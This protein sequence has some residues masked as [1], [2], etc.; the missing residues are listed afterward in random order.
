MTMIF[1][2]SCSDLPSILDFS[3]VRLPRFSP[4]VLHFLESQCFL[5]CLTLKKILTRFLDICSM[6]HSTFL[7][8]LSWVKAP[9]TL[10]VPWVF[11]SLG[12]PS[13]CLILRFRNASFWMFETFFRSILLE[14]WK[15][16]PQLF[17]C[18]L[19][20]PTSTFV[21]SLTSGNAF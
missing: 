2:L 13:E 11:P 20:F 6:N 3:L 5:R 14:F 8:A 12:D 17:T 1:F 9:N 19:S 21:T 10:V 16:D 4:Y 15:R 18:H 7:R